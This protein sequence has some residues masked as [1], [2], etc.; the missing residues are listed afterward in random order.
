MKFASGLN[1]PYDVAVTDDGKHMVVAE[2][3]GNCV[4]VL[5]STGKVV[6]KFGS[7]GNEPGKF[8]HPWCVAVSADAHILVVDETYILQ[9]FTLT[10]SYVASCYTGGFGVAVHP[11]TGKLFCTSHKERKIIVLNADLTPSYSFASDLFIF[12]FYLAIDTKGMVYVTD[13]RSGVIFKF[14]PEGEHLATIGSKGEQP[15]QLH[16]PL[17][18]FIDSNDIMYV[19]DANKHHVMML[20]TEGEFLGIFGRA[21]TPKKFDNTGVA[22]DNSGNLYVCDN[23]NGEVLVS[24]PSQ[25]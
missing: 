3:K 25:N 7:L 21:G 13:F 4:T 19:T 14:T 5:S 9:K 2:Y 10:S 6:R 15:H 16:S 8:K 11:T 17:G 18:I 22:V 24:R 20:T 23:V 1:G 12:P